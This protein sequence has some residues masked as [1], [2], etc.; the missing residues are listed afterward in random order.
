MDGSVLVSFSAV[1][2]LLSAGLLFMLTTLSYKH[3]LKCARRAP[4]KFFSGRM[5]FVTF[6]VLFF[7]VMGEFF[8]Q[9]TNF[10][11]TSIAYSV[12]YRIIWIFFFLFIG[13]S[14]KEE[15]VR[16]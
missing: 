16:G 13:I 14:L 12:L 11:E 5:M 3:Y 1:V 7:A 6:V 10:G 8:E 4:H 2:Q 15:Y 9:Y